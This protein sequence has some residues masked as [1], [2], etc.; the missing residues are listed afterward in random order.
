MNE[1]VT[2]GRDETPIM[3]NCSKSFIIHHAVD[4]IVVGFPIMRMLKE[5]V[6]FVSCREAGDTGLTFFYTAE[7]VMMFSI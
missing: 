1:R 6:V 5:N 2:V 4:G 7:V 3:G